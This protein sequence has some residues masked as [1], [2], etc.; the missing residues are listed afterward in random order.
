MFLLFLAQV[1]A[2]SLNAGSHG[3]IPV[4]HS[5]L[6]VRAVAAGDRDEDCAKLLISRRGA[7]GPTTQHR[8]CRSARIYDMNFGIVVINDNVSRS[9]FALYCPLGGRVGKKSIE[10]EYREG[11]YP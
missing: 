3:N 4:R 9:Q 7:R 2:I 5:P 10:R 11:S 8:F 6:S 1:G